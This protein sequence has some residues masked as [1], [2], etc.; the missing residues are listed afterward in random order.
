MVAAR[1][2]GN[3]V[4]QEFVANLTSEHVLKPNAWIADAAENADINLARISHRRRRDHKLTL[5]GS[6]YL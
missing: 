3:S 5:W 2:D 1:A 6:I 4:K